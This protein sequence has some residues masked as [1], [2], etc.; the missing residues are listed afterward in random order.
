MKFHQVH[1]RKNT[2]LDNFLTIVFADST[3]IQRTVSKR[4]LEELSIQKQKSWSRPYESG[5]IYV[6]S[7]PCVFKA[8]VE[9]T[10]LRPPQ[11]R[12]VG[13]FTVC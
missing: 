13:V 9:N 8:Q 10:T 1:S 6:N 11:I 3:A 12:S 4:I 2:S 5:E 7:D